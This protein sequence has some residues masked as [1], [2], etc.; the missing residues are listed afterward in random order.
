MSVNP[1]Y[2][3][4]PFIQEYIYNHGWTEL[5][6]VQV[7]ACRVIFESEAHLLLAAGTAAGKTEAA[8]LPVI[9]LLHE[10]PSTT[11]GALYIGP[12]KALINDQFMRLNDLL[13]EAHIPVWH[14][15]GDVSQSHKNKMMKDPKGI[16]Q[17]TPE[18]L[19]SMLINRSTDILRLFSDLRFI[20][21]DEVHA[22]MG[23]DR[24][25]Q[26]LCQLER[27][28]RLTCIQPRRIGLSATL[29]DYSLA[30]K[31]LAYGT[32]KTVITP[33]IQSGQQKF[34]L[35]VEHF[36]IDNEEDE[37]PQRQA[38]SPYDEYI[39]NQSI[40]RKCLIFANNREQTEHTIATLR[41]MAEGKKMS[42]IYHVHHG[43]ISAPLREAAE[44]AMKDSQEPCITAATVT[45]EL[46]IDLGQLE[47]VIQLETPLSVSSFLQRLGRSG[48]R[49]TPSEMWLVCKEEKPVQNDLLPNQIPWS[50]LQ[51]IAI[52]Q[53]YLEERWIEP[54]KQKKYPFSLLYHQT[55]STLA[56]MGELAP[57]ALAQRVL[58]LSPF[59]DIPN[60][61]FRQ[62]LLYLIE[63]DH[64]QKT[65]ERGLLIGLAGEQVVGSFRFY[66]VFPDNEEYSV[67][68]ESKEI[69]S[70][71]SPPPKGE[72]FAL[73]GRTWEVLD[74]D[75]KRK[76]IYAKAVKGK[77]KTSWSGGSGN[78]HTKILQRMKKV[79]QEDMV[80]P[81]L[82]PGAVDRLNEARKLARETGLLKDN[83]LSLGGDSYC[84]FPWMG[85]VAYR[86]LD[87]C[88]RYVGADLFGIRNVGGFSPYFLIFSMHDSQGFEIEATLREIMD[89]VVDIQQLVS[90]DEAPKLEKYDEFIPPALLRKAFIYDYL[91][92][93]EAR[94]W[95]FN[96]LG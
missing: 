77:I 88:L 13:E 60:E 33:K 26:V 38:G 18:S 44:K 75:I 32:G 55:M 11:I 30:E 48:R 85:T 89:R 10:N 19:E 87:R 28:M 81:Y 7:E 53:L 39:F 94:H 65:D 22:F 74:I 84:L 64:I 20:I 96:Q 29:G 80:Y 2:R 56:A 86:T 4:A 63:I 69:G 43:S 54:V 47:R 3:L 67:R 8:F 90:E 14:W 72:R 95:L 21:I 35:A 91:D 6:A 51:S 9:T 79:L 71:L 57:A 92:L 27:L 82:Q 23:T 45:L 37:E 17:I 59:K 70:I 31:W 93:N 40:N 68:D 46:G 1:F 36:Y 5:R 42:D 62:L 61:D 24:G 12:L 15:H 52:I 83:I 34:R 73:A 49:G 78:V 25:S 16:L 76:T 66:A 50:L 41:Q 58:T